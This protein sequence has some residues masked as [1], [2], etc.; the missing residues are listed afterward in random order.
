[1]KEEI[2][3]NNTETTETNN[4]DEIK[5]KWKVG[6]IVLIVTNS[7]AA[8]AFGSLYFI[9]PNANSFFLILALIMLATVITAIIVLRKLEK[10]LGNLGK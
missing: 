8:I 7:L 9:L 3:A 2:D 4:I 6:K 10:K 5:R 1:M